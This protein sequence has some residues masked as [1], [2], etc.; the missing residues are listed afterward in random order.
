MSRFKALL[1]NLYEEEEAM[2][3]TALVMEELT[4]LRRHELRNPGNRLL[5]PVESKGLNDVLNRLL[6]GEPVQ[7]VLGFSWFLG[8]R[9]LVNPATLIPRPE[10]EELVTW[11][12]EEIPNRENLR[13]IDLGTGS[14]CIAISLKKAF[15]NSDVFATDLSE[16]AI[17]TAR[18]NA[19]NILGSSKKEKFY[20][21]DMTSPEWW[22]KQKPY[23]VIVSNPP[24]VRESEKRG[25]HRNVLDFEPASALFVSDED[26][27]LYYREVA[28]QAFAR[29]NKEGRLF[30][31]INAAFGKKTGELLENLG[32]SVT[33][34]KDMQGRDRM[35]MAR[36]D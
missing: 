4:G 25:M 18:I 8:E 34:R 28:E 27:L 16:A 9:F 3:I 23:D 2:E 15:P 19:Q 24:Y 10:T 6:Q 31:E 29:L 32:Y 11:I 5:A 22:A 36:K 35:I 13:I 1:G 17:H 20:V 12:K 30:F 7:Y 14:G 33:I 26:P 21:Q